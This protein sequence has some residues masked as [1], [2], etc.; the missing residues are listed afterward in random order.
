MV[1]IITNPKKEHMSKNYL[2]TYLQDRLD[3]R[4]WTQAEFVRLTGIPRTTVANLLY[5]YNKMPTIETIG[6]LANALEVP[7]RQVIEACGV[8]IDAT[9]GEETSSEEARRYGRVIESIKPLRELFHLLSN[10]NLRQINEV[11][12][13]AKG[14][15]GD[16]EN[17]N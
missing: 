15:V 12:T 17:V 9:P 3:E 13:Y 2:K 11:L 14:V 5:G 1:T 16:K 10:A 4:G 6:A 8:Q 7:L